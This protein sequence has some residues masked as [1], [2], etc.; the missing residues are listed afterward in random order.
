MLEHRAVFR[1]SAEACH[2]ALKLLSFQLT[3]DV[4]SVT[5]SSFKDLIALYLDEEIWRLNKNESQIPDI[6]DIPMKFCRAAK[7]SRRNPEDQRG[8]T[9]FG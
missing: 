1:H 7:F 8:R 9:E 3:P 6:Q 4:G 2:E 5:L